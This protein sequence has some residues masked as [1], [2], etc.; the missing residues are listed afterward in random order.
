MELKCIPG[1]ELLK[2]ICL[3][4]ACALLI[5]AV[6][7]QAAA[8]KD[9]VIS[10]SVLANVTKMKGK[11]ISE[12]RNSQPLGQFNLKTYRVEEVSLQKSVAIEMQGKLVNVDRAWRITV[13]GGP[14][15]VR[16]LPAVIWIGDVAVGNGVENERLTEISV[17]VFDRSLLR[18]GAAIALSYGE[19]KNSREELPEKLRLT[20]K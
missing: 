3:A 6:H 15:P 13:T 17:L 19:N 7:T 18:E 9:L 2:K 16:A 5:C 20:G 8:Q 14:F 11:V 1:R 12:G 10:D 4:A